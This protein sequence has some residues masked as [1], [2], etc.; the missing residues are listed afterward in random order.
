[1][2]IIMFQDQIPMKS[3]SLSWPTKCKLSTHLGAIGLL[4]NLVPLWAQ[5]IVFTLEMEGQK[6]T[7]DKQLA[8]VCQVV[9]MV[10][11]VA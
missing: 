2:L 4:N 3:I 8:Q 5:V 9:V 7:A 1:M 11:A 6:H 10:M